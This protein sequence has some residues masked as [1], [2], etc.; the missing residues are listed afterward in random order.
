MP[1]RAAEM[2]RRKGAFLRSSRLSDLTLSALGLTWSSI[3]RDN[4]LPQTSTS[5]SGVLK[6]ERFRKECVSPS[7]RKLWGR[8]CVGKRS[9]VSP[10]VV[11]VFEEVWRSLQ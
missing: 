9:H 11:A 8:V 1:G 6:K 7:M 4:D 3:F 5:P 2:I 10:E